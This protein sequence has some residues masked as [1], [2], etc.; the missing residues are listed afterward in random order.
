MESANQCQSASFSFWRYGRRYFIIYFQV[1]IK[2]SKT[3]S[4][5]PSIVSKF[6]LNSYQPYFLNSRSRSWTSN[7]FISSTKEKSTAVSPSAILSTSLQKSC[8]RTADS[9]VNSSYS[10]ST[11]F[12]SCRQRDARSVTARKNVQV[13]LRISSTFDQT[14]TNYWDFKVDHSSGRNILVYYVHHGR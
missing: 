4:P 10:I 2:Y 12:S 6:R 14:T 7:R 9:A 13:E 1:L 5:S 3:R 11:N 8:S